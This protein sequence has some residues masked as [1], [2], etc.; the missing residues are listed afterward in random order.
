MY[1]FIRNLKLNIPDAA[2][3]ALVNEGG[4]VFLKL[5]PDVSEV[6]T[7]SRK[8]IKGKFGVMAF[9][10]FLREIRRKKFDT[11]FVL[12]NSDRPTIVGFFT[13]AKVR[14]GFRHDSW[15]RACLLTERLRWEH[16]KRPHMIEYYLQ[17]L[18]DTGLT[19][20]D[21]R[22]TINVPED[23]IRGIRERFGILGKRDKKTI[24][25]HPGARTELRQWGP[26]RF[27][28]VIN[29][30][31]GDYRIFLTGGPD[32]RDVVREVQERLTRPPEIV[33]NDLSL[34]E[35]AALCKFAD[36]F[37]GNDSAPIHIAAGVGMFVIGIY[38]P[39]L[40]KYCRPWT[41]R[42]VLFDLS[43]LPCRMCDQVRCIQEEKQACLREITP[44]RV[45]EK[46]R[47]VLGT[48]TGKR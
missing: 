5:L 17:A 34:M 38:G 11:V 43:T 10:R 7:V 16:E 6:I 20:F 24:L 13:G 45:T 32:E 18:T 27:A 47:E 33:S 14:V 4:E 8:K 12:S 25:V 30:L 29:A 1:P 19:V 22:L 42:S 9:I 37:V 2:I 46:I 15:W 35:F 23:E 26:E 39:T 36:L 3:T 31:S 40:S 48:I 44:T 21:R 41:D 28:E